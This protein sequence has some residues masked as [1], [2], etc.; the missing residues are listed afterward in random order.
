MTDRAVPNLPSRDLAATA[1]FYGGFGFI[2]LHRDDGW[3]VVR[4][5]ELQLEFFRKDAL[6]PRGHDF[7]CCL[8]V[9]D[10]Q[11]LYEAVRAAGVPEKRYGLPSVRPIATQPWGQQ[12]STLLDPD[13]NLL[14][15]IADDDSR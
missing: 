4:R 15:M 12:M 8:R 11:S 2:E 6:D 7:G 3:L 5:A 9:A 1:A 13:G 10:L 14:R